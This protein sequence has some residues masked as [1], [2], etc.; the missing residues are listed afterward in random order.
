MQEN[1][2]EES[3]QDD[4]KT[5]AILGPDE[6]VYDDRDEGEFFANMKVAD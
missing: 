2:F 5:T 4:E 1:N 6:I 3:N